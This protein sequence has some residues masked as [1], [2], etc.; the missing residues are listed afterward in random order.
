VKR[1]LVIGVGGAGK[2]TIA[3]PLAEHVG[4]ELVALDRIA[5]KDARR[6]DDADVVRALGPRLAAER[7]VVDGTLM[8]LLDEHVAPLADHVVWVDTP[9]RVAAHRLVRRGRPFYPAAL[10]VTFAGPLVRRRAA[11]LLE[12]HRPHAACVRLRTPADANGWLAA[13]MTNVEPPPLR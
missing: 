6:V 9:L 5:W 2:T 10:H 13:A 4:G 8:D 12:D 7:W 1:V 3:T 11:R